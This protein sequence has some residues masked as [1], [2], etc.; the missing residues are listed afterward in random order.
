LAGNILKK[1]Q[2]TPVL[3]AYREIYFKNL[4]ASVIPFWH[5]NSP[6]WEHGGSFSCLDRR[7]RVFD[8][9]KYTWLVARSAW[10]FAR[11]YNDFEENP[12]FL[13]MASLGIGYLQEYARD[14]NGRYYFSLNREG[15]P[16]F[17]QRKPYGA[18]F[19]MMAYLEYYKSS[20]KDAYRKE[21]I[22]LFWKIHRWIQDPAELGRPRM[23]G[24]PAM[25]NLAD[26][27]VM[28]GMALEL[29]AVESDPQYREVMA[30]AM[31]Q[32]KRHFN[33]ALKVL[34]ENVPLD[35]GQKIMQWPEGR[36]FNP[37]HSIEVA[38]FIMRLLDHFDDREMFSLALEVLG[39]SLDVGW[40]KEFDGIFYFMDI[41]GQPTLQLESGMKLWWP[42]TE[43][44]YALVLAFCRTEDARWL[45]WLDKVHQYAF[46]HFVDAEDGGW[47]GYCDRQG[48]LTHT[49]KGSHYKGFFHVPRALL[50][51]IQE[52]D[53]Y[54]SSH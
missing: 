9:K 44:I 2:Y 47:F 51:C 26:V 17:F 22:D 24:V 11:L 33:P 31:E 48:R 35:P 29:S 53:R 3:Q 23:S 7:G 50:F 20:G 41:E 27:M 21:A 12:D 38:W 18:V 40:D 14:E 13:K 42:H 5:D 15:E 34:M 36:L 52:I 39:G 16:W 6:D 30:T 19:A 49:S 45:G 43:A 8:T 37:G 32:C 25:S 54:V 10:M 28:A 46:S 1:H 4:T